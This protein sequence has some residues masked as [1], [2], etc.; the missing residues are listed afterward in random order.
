MG[1]DNEHCPFFFPK[2]TDI[3]GYRR[4]PDILQEGEHVWISEKLHGSSGRAACMS[5]RLWIGSHTQ[6]KKHDG[7]NIWSRAATENKLEEKLSAF[8]GIAVYFEVYGSKVQDLAYGYDKGRVAIAAFDCMNLETG[9]YQDYKGFLET[10][11]KAGIPVVPALYTGPWNKSL[12]SLAEGKSSLAEHIRE[13]IVIKPIVERF[14][15]RITR[16]VLK[17]H[18]EG[19]LLR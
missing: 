14:D 7:R 3:E 9:K 19:Y 4:W 5:G 16:V 13:G 1:G 18:G 17:H 11:G 2:Y 8:P 12:L 10:T 15:D 6:I